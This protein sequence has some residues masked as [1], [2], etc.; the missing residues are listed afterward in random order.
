M[1]NYTPPQLNSI[2]CDSCKTTFTDP[3][4]IQ[5]FLSFADIAGYG[6]RVLGDM[7]YWSIDLCQDCWYKLLSKFIQVRDYKNLEPWEQLKDRDIF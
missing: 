6:N 1:K 7:T 2:T 4:E 3:L 5:E